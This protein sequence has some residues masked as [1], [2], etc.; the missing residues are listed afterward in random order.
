MD[1]LVLAA[2]AALASPSCS[3]EH[4]DVLSG[5]VLASASAEGQPAT[6]KAVGVSLPPYEAFLERIKALDAKCGRV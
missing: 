6:A 1:A 5:L 3:L 4:R 2:L